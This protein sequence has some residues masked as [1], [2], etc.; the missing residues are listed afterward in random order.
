MEVE[1]FGNEINRIL[2]EYDVQVIAGDFNARHPSWCTSQI[3]RMV[4]N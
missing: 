4:Y 2:T 3:K 1:R